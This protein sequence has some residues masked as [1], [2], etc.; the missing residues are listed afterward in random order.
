D[1]ITHVQGDYA[2]LMNET[3]QRFE[4]GESVFFYTW[5]PNWTINE[6]ALGED[7]VWL[8]TPELEG[9][10][11]L[12]GVAGCTED[13]CNMGFT[14]ND[15]RAVANTEF[16]VA[17]PAI[18]AL[19]SVVEVPLED[20]AAQ[21]VAMQEGADSDDDIQEQ[22]TEWIDDNRESVDEWLAFALENAENTELVDEVVAEWMAELEADM[23]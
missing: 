20:I 9:V 11:A 6:L 10:D 2:L 1:S 16:L 21:N 13:P 8:A 5:T 3:I 4:R 15:I 17:N 22:A 23:E 12:E 18:T 14:G 19:L 7:V